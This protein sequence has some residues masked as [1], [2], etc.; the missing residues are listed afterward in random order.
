MRAK[1]PDLESHLPLSPAAFHVL[2]ALADGEKHGYA[3]KKEVSRRTEEKV[4]LG[5]GTLYGLIKRMLKNGLLVECDER[6]DP[7][8]DDER[9]RYYRLSE[10]GFKVATAEAERMEKLIT[11]ARAKKLLGKTRAV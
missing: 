10:L 5:P 9:R 8:L 3:I 7:S 11:A 6:P 4:R 2:L 1:K